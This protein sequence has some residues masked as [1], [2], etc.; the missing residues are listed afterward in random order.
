MYWT[1]FFGPTT[2]DW[3]LYRVINLSF[4]LTFDMII[5]PMVEVAAPATLQEGFK[6]RAI[7]EGVQFPVVVVSFCKVGAIY[8]CLDRVYGFRS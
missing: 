6:F 3:I 2:I 4:P 8:I 7:Y 5:Q 1:V